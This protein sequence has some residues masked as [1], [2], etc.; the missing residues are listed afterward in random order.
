MDRIDPWIGGL[1][2]EPIR[3]AMVGELFFTIL[4]IQFERLRDGDPFW[5]QR[6]LDPATRNAVEQTRLSD[7]IRRNTT[8]GGELP[9]QVMLAP[10][11]SPY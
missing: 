5:Y 11:G 2:E 9:A 10:R 6:T 4:R 7:I 1:A 3:G 8:I